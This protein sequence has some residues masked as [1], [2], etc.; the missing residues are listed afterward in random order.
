MNNNIN[1]EALEKSKANKAIILETKQLV[2]K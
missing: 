2:K 1:I